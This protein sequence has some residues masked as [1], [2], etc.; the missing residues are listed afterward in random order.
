M[1]ELQISMMNLAHRYATFLCSLDVEMLNRLPIKPDLK[2]LVGR[3]TRFWRHPTNR[4]G[5]DDFL[6]TT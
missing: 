2:N 5:S 4:H 3:L 1:G 6:D